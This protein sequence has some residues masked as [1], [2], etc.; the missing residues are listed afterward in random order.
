MLHVVT[1][2]S[3]SPQLAHLANSVLSAG[4]ELRILDI[5]KWT[6][7]VDKIHTMRAFVA[8]LPADDIV[9]FVDSYDVLAFAAEPEILRKFRSFD[10]EI[11]FSAEL[12]AYPATYDPA[13]AAVHAD[14]GD[15]RF[16][17]E[18]KYL[19]AGGYI[20]YAHALRTLF[21]WRSP[22]ETTAICEWGGD[23][24]YF[25]QYYLEYC[26]D[27]RHIVLDDR[28]MIFQS[29]YRARLT[30]FELRPDG[31][32]FNTILQTAPCFVH[33][34][35]FSAYDMQVVRADTGTREDVRAEIARLA[36]E[37]VA[38]GVAQ[39]VNHWLIFYKTWNGKTCDE[40]PQ[41]SSI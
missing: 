36:R 20:G 37:A 40:L 25:T 10:A 31:R 14:P 7:Y 24:N 2:C 22:E 12:A 38:T 9:C 33:F 41:I 16:A 23:Q 4:V 17:T 34:N 29:M 19:N 28:Q 27:V 15:M 30:E 35:G 3:S 6:S 8:D 11:V 26:R 18:Y 21:A 39:P 5:P 1:A 13:Y 32:F